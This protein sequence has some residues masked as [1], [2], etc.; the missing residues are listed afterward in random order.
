MPAV[1]R[2]NFHYPGGDCYTAV[3]VEH[4][5]TSSGLRAEASVQELGNVPVAQLLVG[6]ADV[7]YNLV[8]ALARTVGAGGA[9]AQNGVGATRL[10]MAP[11]GQRDEKFLRVVVGRLRVQAKVW[12]LYPAHIKLRFTHHILSLQYHGI[13]CLQSLGRGPANGGGPGRLA[14][15][16]Q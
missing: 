5:L 10:N 6:V 4:R 11:G 12:H 13:S 2:V 3:I 8:H 15:G 14:T 16:L 1:E 7:D 9:Y